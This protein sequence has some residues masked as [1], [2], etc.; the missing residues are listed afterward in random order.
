LQLARLWH[1]YYCGSKSK[2]PNLF[3][4][5]D[6]LEAFGIPPP[7]EYVSSFEGLADQTKGE[8]EQDKF[9]VF[10]QINPHKGSE[11]GHLAGHHP[12]AAGGVHGH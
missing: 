8:P 5:I 10:M 7:A 9:P 4:F 6:S 3:D 1:D 11:S 12:P 2:L